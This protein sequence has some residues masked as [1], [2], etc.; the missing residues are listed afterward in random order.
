MKI[1][2]CVLKTSDKKKIIKEYSI[3]K[4]LSLMSVNRSKNEKRRKDNMNIILEEIAKNSTKKEFEE[5]FELHIKNS[6]YK[7]YFDEFEALEYR[8]DDKEGVL[9]LLNQQTLS[10]QKTR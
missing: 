1:T 9:A 5:Y 3:Q 4:L 2:Y 7:G 6:K 8:K 10:K